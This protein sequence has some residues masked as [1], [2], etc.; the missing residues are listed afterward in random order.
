MPDDRLQRQR[1]ELKFRVPSARVASL[2]DFV[3]CHLEPDPFGGVADGAYPVRSVY[4]DSPDF[5]LC[6]A[7]INGDKNRFKLRL[8]SYAEDPGAPVFL[9]LKRRDNDNIHKRRVALRPGAAGRLWDAAWPD[10]R[11]LAEPGP[12]ARGELDAIWSLVRRLGAEPRAL[13]VYRREAWVSPRGNEVRVTFDRDVTCTPWRRPEPGP[14]PVP[15]PDV[16][17][18]EVVLEIKF[19]DRFPRWVG[20]LVGAFNLVR[21]GAAKYVDGLA[22]ATGARPR[23]ALLSGGTTDAREPAAW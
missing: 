19:T 11:V 9:E 7:T 8:R 13:V 18:G 22:C 20:D 23:P 2:C 6:R 17:G 10:E 14:R 3:R 21:C 15:A 1:Y 16:F 5:A 4:L 12:R